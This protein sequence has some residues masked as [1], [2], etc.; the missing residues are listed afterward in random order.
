MTEMLKDLKMMHAHDKGNVMSKVFNDEME[1]NKNEMKSK[2]LSVADMLK[3][4]TIVVMQKKRFMTSVITCHEQGVSSTQ[5]KKSSKRN[6][7]LKT[8]TAE[9]K[10]VHL[11][12]SNINSC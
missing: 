10:T 3:I 5:M 1:P 7:N 11:A 9:N 2:H 12:A 4:K 6:R 8:N